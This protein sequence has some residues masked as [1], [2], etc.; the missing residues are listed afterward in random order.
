MKEEAF[1][2]DVTWL[3]NLKYKISHDS[4]GNDFLSNNNKVIRN[5]YAYLDQFEVVN[6]NGQPAIN[7]IYKGND[8]LKWETN[9]NFNTGVEFGV[10]ENKYNYS[11][12][13]TISGGLSLKF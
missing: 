10:F 11:A 2:Q 9:C 4:H 8:K 5:R 6:N 3:S 13:R 1:L 7:Q 12:L